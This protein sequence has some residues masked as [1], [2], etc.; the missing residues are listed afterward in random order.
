MP[1]GESRRRAEW[2][3]MLNELLA[4]DSGRMRPW[5]LKFIESL[6]R[7]RERLAVAAA[8]GQ[9]W[10]PGAWRPGAWR[11]TRLQWKQL[12]RIWTEVFG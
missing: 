8:D 1:D 6:D 10:R 2:A 12:D 4:D 7:Q 3:K 11:P 5:D 9:E